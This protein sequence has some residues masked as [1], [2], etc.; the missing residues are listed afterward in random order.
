MKERFAKKRES[1]WCD[2]RRKKEGESETQYDEWREIA[3]MMKD[4][5]K[6]KG[7]YGKTVLPFTII[8]NQENKMK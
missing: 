4:G 8:L 5:L 6:K 3:E 2:W 7:L 1:V